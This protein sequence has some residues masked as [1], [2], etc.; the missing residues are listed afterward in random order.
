M[1][2]RFAHLPDGEMRPTLTVS[3]EVAEEIVSEDGGAGGWI[4]GATVTATWSIAQTR[5]AW[6]LVQGVWKK[7]YNGGDGAFTALLTLATQA[8]QTGSPI[9][10]RE[11]PDGLVHEIYLW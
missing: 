10:Y 6:I 9:T 7:I 2:A 4:S 5:N 3:P 1:V 11:E 8:R